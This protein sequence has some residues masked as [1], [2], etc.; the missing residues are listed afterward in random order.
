MI[1]PEPLAFALGIVALVLDIAIRLLSLIFVPRNR[2]PQTALAWLLLI[3]FQP[4]I[5]IVLFWMFES[6]HFSE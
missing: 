5:G 3:F 1:L 4:Y 6:E 2:R